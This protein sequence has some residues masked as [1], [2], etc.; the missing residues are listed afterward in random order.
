MLPEAPG[1]NAIDPA[2]LT[3]DAI[4][5]TG[6]IVLMLIPLVA[7]ALWGDYFGHYIARLRAEREKISEIE[8]LYRIR[9]NALFAILA[10][11]VIFL[12]SNSSNGPR[13]EHPLA[14]GALT[15][16][17]IVGILLFQMS[18]ER[19][20][21]TPEGKATMRAQFRSAFRACAWSVLA[22]VMY[23]VIFGLAVVV[24]TLPAAFFTVSGPV[25]VVM[26]LTG[27]VAGVMGGLCANFALAPVFIRKIFNA[28]TLADPAIVA[29][30]DRIFKEAGIEK[31]NYGV[32][33]VKQY[34][35]ASA[36]VAGF[37]GGRGIFRPALFVAKNVLDGLTPVE[38]RAVVLHEIS[39]MQLQHLRKRFIFSSGL[40]ICASL[41]TGMLVQLIQTFFHETQLG[42]VAGSIALIISFAASFRALAEQTRYQEIQA[43]IHSIEK[44]GST[45]ESLSGA[46]MKLDHLNGSLP[47]RKEPGAMMV[48]AGHPGTELRIRILTRYFERKP[49]SKP[50]SETESD[51]KVA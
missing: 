8:E 3:Q 49:V 6:I 36:M 19:Q 1:L 23:L 48:A 39:H 38:L 33:N 18:C 43:D 41:S 34:H 5:L 10:E 12:G 27:I 4:P 11:V 40:V 9:L 32:I 17:T 22:G 7:Y 35:S 47:Y 20:I 24:C 21:R 44:L 51:Q 30:L 13:L 15:A 42:E 2:L 16:S 28:E 26:L 14:C 50:A 45:L 25:A 31:P 29:E 37:Q 46:L